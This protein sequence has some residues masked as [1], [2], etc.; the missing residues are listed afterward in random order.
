MPNFMAGNSILAG[1]PPDELRHLKP[2]LQ[3]TSWHSGQILR[4]VAAPLD[5]LYFPESGMVCTLA[6]M[7]DGRTVALA[8]IGQEGFLGV[9]AF[10]GAERAQLRAVAIIDED[11][12]PLPLD[13][14]DF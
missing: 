7:D 9:S 5:C 4:D 8:A 13:F 11:G 10:L 6:I 14:H 2:H 3:T 12:Q 1:L